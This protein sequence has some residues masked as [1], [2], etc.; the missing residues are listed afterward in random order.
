MVFTAK[1]RLQNVN[2]P[3]IFMQFDEYVMKRSSIYFPIVP[4]STWIKWCCGILTAWLLCS[5]ILMLLLR[6]CQHYW[7]SR[8]ERDSIMKRL[9]KITISYNLCLTEEDIRCPWGTSWWKPQIHRLNRHLRDLIW[10]SACCLPEL[11]H[12]PSAM[13]DSAKKT[14]SF[15]K[16][17]FTLK[18]YMHTS[19]KKHPAIT[20]HPSFTSL[21]AVSRPKPESHPVMTITLPLIRLVIYLKFMNFNADLYAKN[22]KIWKVALV[23]GI[24]MNYRNDVSVTSSCENV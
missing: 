24:K 5:S 23:C 17:N 16:K 12:H 13:S 1:T 6:R 9:Y 4:K 8:E 21:V 2:H 18:I 15:Q 3:Y 19:C 14:I 22:M 7:P 11:Q 10:W 20:T